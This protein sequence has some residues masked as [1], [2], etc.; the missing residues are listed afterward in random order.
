MTAY[1]G[2]NVKEV[3]GG[4]LPLLEDEV[5]VWRQVT[6]GQEKLSGRK[7]FGARIW[8]QELDKSVSLRPGVNVIKLFSSL[9]KLRENCTVCLSLE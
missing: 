9:L 7:K 3:I 6:L 5:G 8:P 4:I 1:L 2:D